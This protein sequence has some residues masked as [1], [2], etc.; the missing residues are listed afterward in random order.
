MNMN[1]T[2]NT[3]LYE[4]K[5]KVAIITLNRPEA[6]NTI[7][8]TLSEGIFDSLS[9]AENDD[10]VQAIVLTGSGQKAFCAGIDLKELTKN[11]AALSED[12][13]LLNAFAYR[14][15]PLIGAVNGYAI[16][17]GLEIA[18]MCDLLYASENAVFS[19]THCKV[20]IMPAWGMSQKLPRLIGYGRAKEMS[21]SG[22]KIDAQTALAWGLVNRV[23]PIEQLLNEAVKLAS[24]IAN[25]SPTTVRNIKSLI[26]TGANMSLEEAIAYEYK[27]SR[28]HNDAL[29]YSDMNA[30]LNRMRGK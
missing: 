19:D 17:G 16:T 25:N 18:L 13:T 11:P 4:Q 12:D 1:T 20:G 28:T 10:T 5:D 23:F 27:I 24:E 26:D 3:V 9:K 21:L 8:K 7:T 2:N 30:K 15:K 29:D 6:Y 22:R 14:K